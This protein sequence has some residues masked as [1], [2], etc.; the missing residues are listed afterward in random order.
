MQ[1]K[2]HFRKTKAR[3][4]DR[5]ARPAGERDFETAAEAEAVDHRHGR[6]LQRVE[7]VDHR[8]RPA[9]RR[10]D[11]SRIGGA[12]KFIDVGAGDET[13]WLGG[14]NDNSGGPLAFQRREHRVEL[15]HNIGR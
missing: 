11:Q 8:M 7:P 2:H 1:A 4:V 3:A 15:F 5:N 14:A 12:A 9:D 6:N 13:G 10:L